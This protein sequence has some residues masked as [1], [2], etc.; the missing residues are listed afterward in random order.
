[1]SPLLED[2]D[3]PQ[4]VRLTLNRPQVHNAF[5]ETLIAALI[6]ALERLGADDHVRVIVLTGTPGT[7]CVGADLEWMRRLAACGP[8]E[9]EADA[10]GLARLMATLDQCPKPTVA[11]V[12]GPAFGGGVGLVAACDIALASTEA[13]FCLSEV[14]LGLIPAVIAPYV[15]RA[16]GTRA[17]RRLFL[18]GERFDA[19][20]AQALGLVST[21]VSPATLDDALSLVTRDLHRGAPQAQAAAKDLLRLVDALPPDDEALHAETA[22]RIATRRAS[23]EGREGIGAFLDKRPPAWTIPSA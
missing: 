11:V 22:R 6:E 15:A 18:T 16:I 1:M 21:V 5:D 4:V 14:R 20:E 8:E 9:N 23:A 2:R 19:A 7:F 10:H 13:L 12:D 17:C 3:S